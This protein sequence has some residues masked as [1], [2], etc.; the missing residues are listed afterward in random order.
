M[1]K[2]CQKVET[3]PGGCPSSPRIERI[4]E[5]AVRSGEYR[6][7]EEVLSEAV[8]VWQARHPAAEPSQDDRQAAIERLKNFGKTHHLSLRG[9]TIKQLCDEARP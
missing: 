8:S 4:V 7:A 6:S 3:V 1:E 9:I 5:D 2:R